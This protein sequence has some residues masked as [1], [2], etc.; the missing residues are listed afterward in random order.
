MCASASVLPSIG[1][2]GCTT[3]IIMRV[4]S[5]VLVTMSMVAE[6]RG[7][8]GSRRRSRRIVHRTVA[9]GMMLPTTTHM[10]TT[11]NARD[12]CAETSTDC[13]LRSG[14]VIRMIGTAPRSPSHATAT[15][16]RSE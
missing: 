8:G 4:S 7:A 1:A 11:A 3:I 13:A 2:P 12:I 9:P 6:G 10:N 14:M 15:A 16:S 5:G